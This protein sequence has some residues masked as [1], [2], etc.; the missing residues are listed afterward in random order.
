MP[1]AAGACGK[2]DA[3]MLRYL[4]DNP[5]KFGPDEIPILA[6][7]LE[8]AWKSI[9]DSGATFSSDARAESARN[10]LA[11]HIIEAAQQGERDQR[12][13]CESAL[14]HLAK[15]SLREGPRPTD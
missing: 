10:T 7:A 11:K 6:A 3:E 15:S 14:A 1:G 9:L 2:G 4:A 12:R 13:L 5:A 8:M